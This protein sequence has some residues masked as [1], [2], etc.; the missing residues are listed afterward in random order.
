MKT[1]F[2]I[3]ISFILN[4]SNSYSQ[5]I[6]KK[7]K[8]IRIA[9]CHVENCPFL[10]IPSDGQSN[11]CPHSIERLRIGNLHWD[12]NY[13]LGDLYDNRFIFPKKIKGIEVY[14]IYYCTVKDHTPIKGKFTAEELE[15]MVVYKFKNKRNCIKYWKRIANPSI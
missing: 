12:S 1:I 3:L 10:Q 7:S 14:K 8:P 4:C 5:F 2:L 11:E 9:P 6:S 15:K 13:T